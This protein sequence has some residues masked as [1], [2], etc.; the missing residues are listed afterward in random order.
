MSSNHKCLHC[1]APARAR[2]RTN[3][4]RT[5]CGRPCQV[6]HQQLAL[7]EAGRRNREE[8]EQSYDITLV[9]SDGQEITVSSHLLDYS[10]M[11]HNLS[12]N[13][14]E[15]R[16]ISLP[17]AGSTLRHV[18]T[19]LNR[20]HSNG[21]QSIA[22]EL[23]LANTVDDYI[24]L[25]GAVDF[26]NMDETGAM[27]Y[28]CKWTWQLATRENMENI[29]RQLSKD[30]FIVLM[31]YQPTAMDHNEK[32]AI[33]AP[34]TQSMIIEHLDSNGEKWTNQLEYLFTELYHF[35]GT[36]FGSDIITIV[37]DS[38]NTRL[39]SYLFNRISDWRN[40]IISRIVRDTEN[41]HF[42]HWILSET[43]FDPNAI[44]YS[45]AEKG[46]M[47][48]Q[49]LIKT[50]LTKYPTFSY[51]VFYALFSY[52]LSYYTK[53]PT[54]FYPKDI[55]GVTSILK[56]A[57]EKDAVCV[58]IDYLKLF[59]ILEDLDIRKGNKIAPEYVKLM[60]ILGQGY[61]TWVNSHHH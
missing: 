28:A 33:I 50:F 42:A 36:R 29:F 41:M 25:L 13:V 21:N 32:V 38:Q 9:S 15:S 58:A 54:S 44:S 18:V 59:S 55:D 3:P 23:P 53:I 37:G 26:L 39:Y 45:L 11:L 30:L 34:M 43:E 48:N 17:F 2:E 22:N 57:V 1:Q 16:R 35:S 56:W 4:Q 6:A 14:Q 7:V 40:D 24:A 60:D 10:E 12:S 49:E 19:L 46:A 20:F 61:R 52:R 5:W 27:T 31:N 51:I 8:W 47:I